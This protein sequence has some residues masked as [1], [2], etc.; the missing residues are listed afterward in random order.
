MMKE[1]LFG[2]AVAVL[3]EHGA[4]GLTMDRVA[5]AAGV[6]KGSLYRYF[7]SK[8]DLVEFV[9][10]KMVDPIIRE[11]E[12]IVAS[13]RPALEKLGRQLSMLLEHVAKHAK[14][15]RL[16][17][18]D[19]ITHA[20]LQTS[21]T[22]SRRLAEIFRQGMVEGVFRPGDP[23]TLGHMYLG[24]VKGAL[25]SRPELDRRDQRE[26]FHRV[27]LEAFLNGIAVKKG[28]ID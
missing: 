20:L 18:E 28:Q 16:L 2:A 12:E 4:D 26:D 14:V 24:V 21:D 17:F 7:R 11:E 3:G 6:A 1:A 13:E 15:Y 9:Y 8:R 25:Q 23:Q 22:A 10:T 5:S 19:E 27:I